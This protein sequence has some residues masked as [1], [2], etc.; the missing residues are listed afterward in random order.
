[1]DNIS[2]KDDTQVESNVH[3]TPVVK[4]KVRSVSEE[5]INIKIKRAFMPE[6]MNTLGDYV[7]T[8]IILPELKNGL[9][10][11]LSGAVD[12]AFGIKPR[13]NGNF[14]SS[15]RTNTSYNYIDRASYTNY[16]SASSRQSREL[17]S[18]ADQNLSMQT[19]I[20]EF[21][22]A[23]D[24]EEVLATASDILDQYGV[25]SVA[26]MYELCG[27]PQNNKY[28]LNRYGWTDIGQASITRAAGGGQVLVLPKPIVIK[29]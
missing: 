15:T 29:R 18:A 23:E 1:M 11:I 9:H 3:V 21:D 10:S 2:K 4:G 8:N 5:P 7:L 13:R 16:T 25:I 12:A 20:F 22:T 6:D 26:T 19:R 28:T 17:P 14:I 27:L 24:A